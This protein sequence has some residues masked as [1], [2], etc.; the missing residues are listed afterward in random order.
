[1]SGLLTAIQVIV[2]AVLA[3]M[4][5]FG[6]TSPATPSAPDHEETSRLFLK[7]SFEQP[8]EATSPCEDVRPA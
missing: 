8:V 4:F 1:M 5:G 2:V 7:I 6:D 3:S